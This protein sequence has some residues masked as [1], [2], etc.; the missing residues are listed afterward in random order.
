MH[1][2]TTDNCSIHALSKKFPFKATVDH[3]RKPSIDTIQRSTGHWMSS[4]KG[5]IY[6][7]TL[8]PEAQQEF[9]KPHFSSIVPLF[10]LVTQYTTPT[11]VG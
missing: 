8:T 9:F 2:Y 1:F 5:H 7:A 4:P 11:F 6:N 3:Y 10:R